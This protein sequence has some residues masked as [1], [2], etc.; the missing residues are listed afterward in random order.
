M[1]YVT[2]SN[3]DQPH[4]NETVLLAT[5][6]MTVESKQYVCEVLLPGNSPI[7]SA[8]G[9]PSSRKAIAKRSA[10]FEACLL[11]RKRGYLD[12]N[13]L[14]TY[15]KQLPA[16]RNA[17][18]ALNMKKT[19]AYEMRIKPSVWEK[20]RGSL[21]AEL[22][23]TVL[24]L[25]NPEAMGRPYQPLALLTRTPLLT[26]PPFNLHLQPGQ[27]SS[28]A[29]SSNLTSIKLTQSSLTLL[30]TFT[31]RIFKDIF[32][33]VYEVNEPQ[34][35]YWLAPVINASPQ[36]IQKRSS[37]TLIDWKTLEFVHNNDEIKWDSNM[38]S[39][40][41]ANR[42]LVDRWDGGRRFFSERVV[43]ELR[44]LDPLPEGCAP[45]KYQDNILDYTVSLFSKSRTRVTWNHDQP[46]ILAQRIVHRRNWLDDFD[47][48]EKIAKTLSYVCP[49]PLRISAVRTTYFAR[50][51]CNSDR[52]A[53]TNEYCGHG[54]CVPGHPVPSR[55]VPHRP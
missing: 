31:L 19:N 13:L 28:V 9:R 17:H 46:V 32:N 40:A 36:G 48:S 21:P 18:L 15:H 20:T 4:D 3:I 38:S 41:L 14:P 10:A 11:L 35:S 54:L 34:M 26:F 16:M 55:I 1:K 47:D 22:H 24:D 23:L 49:E 33:K 29:C 42:F 12:S 50:R 2:H 7:R 37:D 5:Y 51:R 30:T 53:A 8:T 6:I 43:P 25:E 27:T 44:P 52:I 39:D 45:H